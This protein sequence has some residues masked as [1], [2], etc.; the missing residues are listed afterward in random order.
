MTTDP[1]RSTSGTPTGHPLLDQARAA[2]LLSRRELAGGVVR[3]RPAAR[4]PGVSSVLVGGHP[5]AYVREAEDA[6]PSATQRERAVLR[7]VGPLDVAPP[8]IGGAVGPQLWV[9]A[10]AGVEL[11]ALAGDVTTLARA[12]QALGTALADLHTAAPAGA[13]RWAAPRPW[14]LRP[15]RAGSYRTV[16]GSAADRVRRTVA[17]DRNLR[18]V[19]EDVADRWTEQAWIHGDLR[20]DRVLVAGGADPVVRFVDFSGAGLGDPGW[21]VAAA[22]VGIT[23]LAEDRGVLPDVLESYF[24]RAYRRGGGPGRLDPGLRSL[25]YVAA[26]WRTAT[27]PGC[28]RR[29]G[30]HRVPLA[31]SGSGPGRPSRAPRAAGR[32]SVATVSTGSTS[33]SS[34]PLGPALPGAPGSADSQA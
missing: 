24:L 31:G 6:T 8:L 16:L 9:G 20:P 25:Q 19:A 10:V 3:I 2:G 28:R 30:G 11:D 15:E 5:V 14:L 26:A 17:A 22:S 27:G 18:R 13:G 4:R 1:N 32:L 33:S 23:I 21:D 29:G 12:C 34:P 7:A